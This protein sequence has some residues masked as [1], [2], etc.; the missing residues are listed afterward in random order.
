MESTI[1]TKGQITLPKNV[2]TALHL[3]TGDKVIFE[4]QADGGFIIRPKMRD[5][6]SLK[7]C[8]SYA[9]PALSIEEMNPAI[10]DGPRS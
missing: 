1:T 2:R 3:E 4:E 6:R 7:G 9:G 10:R 8:V 5:V